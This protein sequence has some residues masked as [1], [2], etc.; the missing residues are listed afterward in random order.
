V[1][2]T[3]TYL[4]L[5]VGIASFQSAYAE[6]SGTYI[7]FDFSNVIVNFPQAVTTPEWQHT[8]RMARARIGVMLLP[9]IFPG[10]ALESQLA[11][12][13]SPETVNFPSTD[14]VVGQLDRKLQ[15][16]TVIGLYIR[17]DMYN[18][19]DTSVYGLLGIAS[20]QS[21]SRHVDK[22]GVTDGIREPETQTGI[23]FGLGFTYAFSTTTS[24]QVEYMSVVRKQSEV[25]FDVRSASVGFN[26]AFDEQ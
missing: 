19:S 12:G 10:L 8:E 23:S 26:F 17:G 3:I 1:V 2:N 21:S 9:D 16:E 24:M 14:P 4:L 25:G 11:M 22:L 13:A 20:A 7:G 5:L 15:L 18:D 6:K